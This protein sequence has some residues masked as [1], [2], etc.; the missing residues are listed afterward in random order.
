MKP[1]RNAIGDLAGRARSGALQVAGAV[2]GFVLPESPEEWSVL[3]GMV[4]LST[5]CLVDPG[6]PD[7]WAIA[8]P[9]VVYLSL[10]LG[11]NLRRGR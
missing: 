7:P 3:A 2:V 1:I 11:L 8:I 6:I 4:L 10:G 9:G 5:W